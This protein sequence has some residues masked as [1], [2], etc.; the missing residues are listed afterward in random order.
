M[1]YIFPVNPF[2]GQLYPI[3]ATPGSLQYQWNAGL[4]AWLIFSPLGVQS[5]TGV[6]PIVVTNGTDN[7]VVSIRPATIN[8]PGSMSAADKAKLDGI[9][10]D[11][12]SGTV[13]QVN[14]GDGLIGGPITTSGTIALRPASKL[15]RG[16]VTVGN[17]IDVSL[18]GTISIPTASFGVTSL[19]LGP[20]LI[21]SPSP[22]TT[23]G[24]ISAAIATRLTVGSV[25][26]GNGLNVAPDGTLSVGG[27][28]GDVGV[29][30][31]GTI[32]VS[33]SAP[34]VFTLQEGYNI[35]S[36]VWMGADPTPR[37]RVNFQNPL[38]NVTYGVFTSAFI[39]PAT[40]G[41]YY[42]E[43]ININ[44]SLKSTTGVD[45]ACQINQTTDYRVT[46]S[47]TNYWNRWSDMK[48][49]DIIIVDT[50]VY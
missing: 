50:A 2:D 39:R 3:P 43:S 7:A 5:V 32:S 38:A 40:L 35:S 48:E 30:A 17:N 47:G 27:S 23:T 6:L 15:L 16:G 26:I 28:L 34:Y 14:T 25:R 31:W 13:T 12:K 22:I 8:T 49:F 24:T 20:G 9:P 1:A 21:G 37:V 29:L 44:P 45:L 36:I 10:A 46:G 41:S 11:A 33:S 42:Q 18:D 4:K 19:N